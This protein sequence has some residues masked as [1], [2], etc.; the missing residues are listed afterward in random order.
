MTDVD[1]RALIAAMRPVEEAHA[2]EEKPTTWT[3]ADIAAIYDNPESHRIARGDES[4]MSAAERAEVERLSR[5]D[6]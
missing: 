6:L 4:W 1:L 5:D 2:R 3:E